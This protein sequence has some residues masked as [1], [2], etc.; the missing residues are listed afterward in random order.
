MM[1]ERVGGRKRVKG[2]GVSGG[3]ES[4]GRR[5]PPGLGEE[6]VGAGAPAGM[7]AA[8]ALERRQRLRRSARTQERAAHHKGKVFLNLEHV[9]SALLS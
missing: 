7:T 3:G 6:W 5:R 4:E 8:G 1:G 2:R 9:S